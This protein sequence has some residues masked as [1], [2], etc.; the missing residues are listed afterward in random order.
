MEPIR[1]HYEDE[2]EKRHKKYEDD[3]EKRQSISDILIGMKH[4]MDAITKGNEKMCE[5]FK[6]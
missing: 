1:K 5:V 6:G 4:M 3:M 2:I